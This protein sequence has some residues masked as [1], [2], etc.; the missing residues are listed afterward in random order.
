MKLGI[1]VPFT[2]G[3]GSTWYGRFS[4]PVERVRL[5][6]R[7]GYDV[8][9]VADTGQDCFGPMG[10]VLGITDQ[11]GVGSRVMQVG[12]RSPVNAAIAFQTLAGMANGRPVLAGIGSSSR[13]RHEGWHGKAW[14][15]PYTRMC[16]Y[17]EVM[18]KVFQGGPLEHAGREYTMPYRYPDGTSIDPTTVL[19]NP[20]PSIPILCGANGPSMTRLAAEIAD[21]WFAY[22]FAP[23]LLDFFRPTLEEGFAR[24]A[25]P[26]SL[27]TFAVWAHVDVIVADDVHEAMRPFK[28]Y[29]ALLHRGTPQMAWRGYPDAQARVEELWD[30]GR[31]DEAADAVPDEYVD[32]GMLVGPLPRL[33]DRLDPWLRSG[34]AGLVIRSEDDRAYEPLLRAARA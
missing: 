34:L 26:K 20:F 30:A 6:D 4:M 22:G 28:R 11:I 24:A 9:F 14:A 32:D 17:V 2:A 31:P 1:E 23:G 13:V 33:V 21:G 15:S 25:A 5:A 7:L 3:V 18:R 8:V 29:V 10:Y 19:T 12:A 27:E 16:E